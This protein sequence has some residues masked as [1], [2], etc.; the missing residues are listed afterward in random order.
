MATAAGAIVILLLLFIL[1]ALV[2]VYASRVRKVGPN[3][4]LVISGRRR[5]NPETGEI[6]PYRIVKGGRAFIWPVLER[7]DLLSLEIMTIEVI[8]D[9]V[10][11][12][13]GVAITLE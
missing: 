1:F 3:E 6:E 11:T 4:V 7:V 5:R 9:D 8:T 2:A 12:S 13:Q 10:Y